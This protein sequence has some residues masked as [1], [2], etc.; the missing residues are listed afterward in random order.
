FKSNSDGTR[1]GVDGNCTYL[2]N[3]LKNTSKAPTTTSSFQAN[4]RPQEFCTYVQ[5]S[6][7]GELNCF[8]V[9]LTQCGISH[10]KD[11]T[12]ANTLMTDTT[13]H[14][15]PTS[16][17]QEMCEC[18]KDTLQSTD[19]KAFQIVI[20]VF[21]CL[22]S[23]SFVLN[24]ILYRYRK[25]YILKY[26]EETIRTSRNDNSSVNVSPDDNYEVCT[27]DES[28]SGQTV[29]SCHRVI[30]VVDCGTY[31]EVKDEE[32]AWLDIAN[33]HRVGVGSVNPADQA[34]SYTTLDHKGSHLVLKDPSHVYGLNS[35][36][37]PSLER[38]HD[39]YEVCAS[40]ES[41]SIKFQRGV[42]DVVDCGNYSE[43]KEVGLF[44]R[45]ISNG[46]EVCGG[47]SSDNLSQTGT[48]TGLNHK[49]SHLAL[50]D[51]SHVYGLN[52]GGKQ[53]SFEELPNNQ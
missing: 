24:I 17:P 10:V 38:P 44:D 23:I 4:N 41:Y 26:Q 37:A 15:Q 50:N 19:D 25:T 27:S 28:S 33:G 36:S 48:Y 18:I 2:C 11:S 7:G 39:N 22:L 16:L 1:S 31:S 8:D 34:T 20:A 43:A 49:G 35:G 53:S 5:R 6:S 32:L 47:E 52:S 9:D 42:S 40:D 14:P 29:S 13:F 45:G 12:T 46:Q 51:P 21:G 30:D 3:T